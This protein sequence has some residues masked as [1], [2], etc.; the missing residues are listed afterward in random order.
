MS[1]AEQY[2]SDWDHQQVSTHVDGSTERDSSGPISHPCADSTK[3]LTSHP[4]R[5]KIDWLPDD[6]SLDKAR[7]EY[8]Y[9]LLG[10]EHQ[11]LEYRNSMRGTN[12]YANKKYAQ[13]KDFERGVL[14]DFDELTTVLLTLTCSPYTDSNDRKP[15]M[16]QFYDSHQSHRSVMRKLDRDIDARSAYYWVNA[17]QQSGANHK[18][19]AQYIES[20][21]VT[22]EDF[23][24]AI[25][26]H[27]KNTPGAT[28]EYHPIS[29]AV[30]I[31]QP[32]VTY[33]LNHVS[34]AEQDAGR[35]P[36]LSLSSYL[37][38]HL[39]GVNQRLDVR[40]AD[41][42][43]QNHAAAAWAGQMQTFGVSNDFGKYVEIGEKL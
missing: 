31:D 25:D 18:H 5:I 39:P 26:L 42:S 17:P 11:P 1:G 41:E 23:E 4:N 43:I 24:G 28:G 30:K 36:T 37:G 40:T 22:R 9:E 7:S 10:K 6:V 14:A 35:T 34:P 19:I 8:Q 20:T 13:T 27:V 2:L 12:Q 32:D 29:E 33:K 16:D 21:D 38:G 15:L 3:S